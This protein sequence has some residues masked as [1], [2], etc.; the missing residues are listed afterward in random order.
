MSQ[1]QHLFAEAV[2]LHQRGLLHEAEERYRQILTHLPDNGNVLANLAIVCRDLGKLQEAESYA[3]Q[4]LALAPDNPGAHLNLG[5]ILEAG[6]KLAEAL[7]TYQ[8]ATT[9]FPDHPKILNNLG[10]LLHQQGDS[11]T[12]RTLLHKALRLFPEYPA[13]LNNLAVLESDHGDLAAAEPLLEQSVALDPD[14]VNTL[15]NR[16]TLC[17][18][19]R[20]EAKAAELLERVLHLAPQ[21]QAA[22]HM[23]S[24]LRGTTPPHA[25]R[26][27]VEEVFDRY[28]PRFDEHLQKKLGYTAPE[29][30]AE[31]VRRHC[32]AQLPF[33]ATLDLGCGT[34][35]SG[36]AFRPLS[37]Q[38]SG[39]DLSRL[40]LQRAR[41]KGLYDRLEQDELLHFLSHGEER[42]AAFVAADVL[43]YVGDPEPLFALIRQRADDDAVIACSIERCPLQDG[44]GYTL[45]P[46]G[47]YAHDPA[48]LAA[49][50]ARHGFAVLAREDHDIRKED[51][52]WLA[53]DLFLFGRVRADGQEEEIAGRC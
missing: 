47:R 50:A 12:A 35:L 53:G 31:M 36:A 43:V 6:G 46:S 51:G 32:A 40:M 7:A 25:P 33:A 44:A 2:Q 48:S 16:A 24:A 28:A 3:R 26:R 1:L 52:N 21:H 45:R 14:N 10:K 18:A 20:K 49:C 30:L 37:A 11:L 22:E 38:L 39:V 23:L 8:Q 4:G 19:R 15:Y 29:A 42:Y 17:N 27:Y 34:G 5:A 13:A 41:E 9:L